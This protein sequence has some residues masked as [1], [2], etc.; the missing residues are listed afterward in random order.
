[1]IRSKME[2]RTTEGGHSSREI[3]TRV[4]R[5]TQIHSHTNLSSNHQP[6]MEEFSSHVK[7]LRETGV[8]CNHT[9]VT[10]ETT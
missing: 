10:Y 6:E 7:F 8:G 1:M 5:N 4:A 9:L 2:L 3:F